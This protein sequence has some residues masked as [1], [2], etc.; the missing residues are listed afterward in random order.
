MVSITTKRTAMK[1]YNAILIYDTSG[2]KL[3]FCHRQKDPYKGKYNFVGGKI[4]QGEEGFAAAYRELFEE[5]GISSADV[6]LSHLM[7]FTYY[8][9]D[10]YL[11]IYAGRLEHPVKLTEEKNPLIWFLETE[12]FFDTRKFAGDG[13]IGHIVRIA[14]KENG[15]PTG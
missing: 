2:E 6:S 11:E 10:F 12:D 1:G 8:G 15:Y 7:D 3:L 13:N 9:L 5:T 14:G 4:E